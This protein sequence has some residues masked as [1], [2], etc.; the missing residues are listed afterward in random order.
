MR[1]EGPGPAVTAAD[2]T[3]GGQ[4]TR[5]YEAGDGPPL[6]LVHG[7]GLAAAVWWPHMPRLADAGYRVLAPDL[8][9]FGASE[10]PRSGLSVPDTAR[11]LLHLG[12]ELHLRH[13][14]WVGHSIST[15][16]LLHLA[17]RDPGGASALILAA[18]TGRRR[19]RAAHQVAGLARDAFRERPTLVKRIVGRYLRNPLPTTGTWIRA[20]RDDP[21]SYADRVEC[22]VLVVVGGR[23]P[24]AT[25]SFGRQLAER[26]PHGRLERID[27]AAHAVALDP[28]DVFCRAVVLFL[29]SAPNRGP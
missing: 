6:V 16:A 14:A 1:P 28:A 12:R 27:G 20:L 7:L 23:D 9:G 29:T 5:I 24:I 3:I 15:Q 26:L 8:P 19:A 13:P 10:G 17:A 18:P 21:L 22:P 4:R 11:W 2:R 25:V